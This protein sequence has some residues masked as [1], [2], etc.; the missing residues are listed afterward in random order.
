MIYVMS[1]IHGRYSRYRS[2]MIQIRLRKTDH[3]YVLGDCIDRNPFGFP[4]LKELYRKPNVTVL[5]GNH[6]HKTAVVFNNAED[7]MAF[8]GQVRTDRGSESIQSKIFDSINN[9][10]GLPFD[11]SN[12]MLFI[13]PQRSLNETM[14]VYGSMPGLW[15][16]FFQPR[17]SKG[18]IIEIGTPAHHEIRNAINL[19]RITHGLNVDFINIE[20]IG[21]RST[22]R[23]TN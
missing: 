20:R 2:V 12:I 13:F 23:V 22:L 7:F 4:T 11:N 8:F 19:I 21:H 9:Y 5:L 17:M 16:F 3:L 15:H 10:D 6:E 14:S 18:N 1:D